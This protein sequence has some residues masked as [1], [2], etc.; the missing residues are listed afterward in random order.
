MTAATIVT[1]H[2]LAYDW[3]VTGDASSRS[4]YAVQST[5]AGSTGTTPNWSIWEG[6]GTNVSGMIDLINLLMLNN[7]MNASQRTALTN[8]ANA[9][10]NSDPTVQARKRAQAML[11]VVATS[12]QFQV[13]R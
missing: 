8:T 11:Y 3:T 5:I 6:F 12:P 4:E 1:R 10:S 7:T 2:N 13:D 9:I